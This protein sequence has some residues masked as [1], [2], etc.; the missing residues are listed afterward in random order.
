LYRIKAVKD[1]TVGNYNVNK[2][3]L[4]GFIQSVKNLSGNAWVYDDA[5]VFGNAQVSGN[6]RVTD[7]VVSLNIQPFTATFYIDSVKGDVIQ[8]GCTQFTVENFV[9][10]VKSTEEYKS[11]KKQLTKKYVETALETILTV[12]KLSKIKRNKGKGSK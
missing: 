10:K 6:A 11:T 9:K 2:G 3:E 1:F 12:Q 7:Y 4:G 8:L 5:W